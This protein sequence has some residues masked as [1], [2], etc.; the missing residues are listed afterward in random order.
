MQAS[1]TQLITYP[2]KSCAGINHQQISINELGLMGDRQWMLVDDDGLFISQRKYPQMALIK[3]VINN[4]QLMVDA[5]GMTTLTIDTNQSQRPIKITLWKD[6]FDAQ[7]INI[8]ANQWFSDYLGFSVRLVKYTNISHRLI[9]Q[10]FAQ[11]G[12]QVAFAD[13]FPLLVTHQA[14]LTDL[15]Q[16][17]SESVDMSRFRPNIVV[18]SN[19]TAWDELNWSQLSSDN[20]RLNLVKP[21]TRC[22]MTGVEQKSGHQTGTEVLKTLRQNFPHDNKAV[23]GINAIPQI[24]N[25]QDLLKVGM[26]LNI[27]QNPNSK[28]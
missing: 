27:K 17:L 3:P 21:C 13:G 7:P 9:D 1:I 22:V 6:S 12:Q 26:C 8:D 15:N 2:I 28:A 18:A 20:L 5:P 24:N 10:N 19:L 14:T 16:H 4:Q 23:F 11:P 25:E